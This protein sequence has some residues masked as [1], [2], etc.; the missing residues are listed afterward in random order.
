MR[1]HI[2]DNTI[3]K[4]ARAEINQENAENYIIFTKYKKIILINVAK[5]ISLND[6]KRI[7][8]VIM[9]IIS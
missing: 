3:I 6:L 1:F 4:Q 8:L 5:Y 9:H 7:A 2:L